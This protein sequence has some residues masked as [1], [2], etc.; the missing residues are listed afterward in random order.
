[1]RPFLTAVAASLLIALAVHGFGRASVDPAAS[2][3]RSM[4]LLVFEHSDCTSCQAFRSRIAPRY[5]A[6]PQ[7][8]EAPLRYVDVASSEADRIAL[9]SPITM[10]PTVVLMKQGHEVDRIAGYWGADN[11]FKMVTYLIARAE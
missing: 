8:A 4:E 2:S 6:S 3:T 10:V 5:Q 1:M 7:A 11:F 9:K